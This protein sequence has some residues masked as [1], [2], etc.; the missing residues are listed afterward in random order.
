MLRQKLKHLFKATKETYRLTTHM[1]PFVLKEGETMPIYKRCSRCGN[2][3]SSGT[4][5]PCI[6]EIETKR[7]KAKDKAYDENIRDKKATAFYLSVEW[8]IVRERAIA[9]Y[10]GVDIYSY[11]ILNKIEYGHTVHHIIPL[12]DCWEKRTDKDNLIYLAESNHQLLHKAMRE[13]KYNETIEL[14]QGL[15]KKFEQEFGDGIPQGGYRKVLGP[16]RNRRG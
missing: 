12:K 9:H 13:G 10:T 6:I 2:R 3:I 5:C 16:H 7:K 14:L 11:Y 15:V 8:E 4:K 1:F